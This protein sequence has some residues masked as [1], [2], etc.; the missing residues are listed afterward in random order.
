MTHL[1]SEAKHFGALDTISCFKFENYLG[2]I[3]KF[4]KKKNHIATQ[5]YNRLVEQSTFMSSNPKVVTFP[6]NGKLTNGSL[7]FVRTKNFYLSKKYP[8]N[9]YYVQNEVFEIQ[10]ITVESDNI[11]KVYSYQILDLGDLFDYPLRSS[12][13][14]IFCTTKKT[15]SANLFCH[16]LNDI[17]HKIMLLCNSSNE[18]NAFFPV[19]HHDEQ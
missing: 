14:K 9:Y 10:R 17:S 5:I 8:D 19:I 18:I 4:V 1:S 7:S 15:Y 13:L 12:I 11:P 6:Q 2:K 3:K 16:D